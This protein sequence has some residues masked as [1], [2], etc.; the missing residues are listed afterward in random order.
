MRTMSK[1][2]YTAVPVSISS[3]DNISPVKE[4]KPKRSVQSKLLTFV[5]ISAFVVAFTRTCNSTPYLN[6]QDADAKTDSGKDDKLQPTLLPG[7]GRDW[8]IDLVNNKI[9]AKHAPEF[10]LG[11]LPLDPLILTSRNGDNAIRFSQEILEK[12]SQGNNVPLTSLCLQFPDHV[13]TFYNWDYVVTGVSEEGDHDQCKDALIVSYVDKN[14][15]VLNGLWALDVAFWKFEEGNGVNF[16]KVVDHPK[17]KWWEKKPKTLEYGGGRDWI[18]NMDDGT[19]SPKNH[20]GLVLGR[21]AKSLIIVDSESD[22]AWKF[23]GDALASLKD[24]NVMKLENENGVGALKEQE[25]E[26]YFQEWRYI[27]SAIR[28]DGSVS[29][30]EKV[31]D[32]RYIDDNYLALYAEDIPEEKSLVLD[33]SFWSMFQ[34]NS[35]NYVGGWVYR[36]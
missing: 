17:T 13:D 30:N 26:Q 27:L 33:V 6:P 16:V 10:A 18:L 15:I 1:P 5:L 8:S 32:V 14:F 7:G 35:V 9:T 12:M 20:P 21:G 28:N 3:G 29:Q 31:I 19:I 23:N 34:Y 24:G 4:E 36:Y 2:L 25:N 22:V 11:S